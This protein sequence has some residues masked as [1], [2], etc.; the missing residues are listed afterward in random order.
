MKKVL[1]MS[2]AALFLFTGCTAPRKAII[3]VNDQTITQSQFNKVY[4]TI[5][6]DETLAS[7]GISIPKDDN[8]Y[9]YLMLKDKV[10]NE[11][12]VKSLVDQE[13]KK[14][15]IKVTNDDIN[16]E[17][18]LMIDK[19]GSKEKFEAILKRNGISNKQF[20]SDLKDEVKM[21][22]LVDMIQKVKVSD[23]EA[24]T[25]YKKNISKFT[26]P[27][28]VRA[29]HILIMANPVAITQQLQSKPENKGISNAELKAKVDTE[30]NKQ[31]QKAQSLQAELK[32]LPD[33]F[34][35]LARTNSEDTATAKNGGDLGFFAK[36]EMVE[37][38]SKQAFSQRPNTI[39]PVV[40]TQFGYHIIKVTDRMAAGQEPYAKV[41]EQIKLY[42][43]TQ[44][45]MTIMEKLITTLKASAKI[46]YID[47]SYDP[48]KIQQKLKELGK[49]K[50]QADQSIH[51]EKFSNKG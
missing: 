49:Q 15:H 34:E 24:Q 42:L 12:I 50:Q 5:A 16:S 11:L 6:N 46:E 18:K 43:Q 29:S 7:M 41:K 37:Q 21:R 22:K 4:K 2:L 23:G 1:L 10:V 27:D 51:P 35:K 20:M 32:N 36:N 17:L 28:K 9:M 33:N 3:K 47:Q 19:V 8:N 48:A 30:M 39:S 26:Y 44:K 14:H 40:Q 25:F 31:Y 38:F 13:I 45:Q